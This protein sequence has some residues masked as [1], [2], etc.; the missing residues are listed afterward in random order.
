MDTTKKKTAY[1]AS[2]NGTKIATS[3]R[4]DALHMDDTDYFGIPTNEVTMDVNSG[5]KGS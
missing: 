2:T 5:I 4:F 1:V 3:N